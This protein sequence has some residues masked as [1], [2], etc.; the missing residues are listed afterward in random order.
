MVADVHKDINGIPQQKVIHSHPEEEI[1]VL[2][3]DIPVKNTSEPFRHS[4][5][6]R[7]NILKKSRKALRAASIKKEK[8]LQAAERP[9]NTNRQNPETKLVYVGKLSP[10]CDE[11]TLR[12]HLMEI[13][14]KSDDIADIIHL[15][16]RK[17]NERSYCVS[18]NTKQAELCALNQFKWPEGVHVRTLPPTSQE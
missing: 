14:I 12:G 5:E 6:Q 1:T 13:G 16:S 8:S 9:I 10:D 3:D 15:K 2:D 18:L 11:Q 7:R 17:E 4:K